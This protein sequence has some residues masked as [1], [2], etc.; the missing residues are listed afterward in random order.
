VTFL[1]NHWVTFFGGTVQVL[2]EGKGVER[3]INQ[4]TRSD[5]VIWNVKRQGTS[6][7]TFFIR[8]HH[9]H[10]LRHHVK[11]YE[12]RVSFLRGQGAP[13]LWKRIMKNGGFLAGLILFFAIITVLSNVVWG[14]QIKGASPKTEYQIRKELSNMGI[15]VGELQFFIDDVETIQHDLTN[16]IPN[17]TWVGVVLKGTTFHFQVVE[18]NTPKPAKPLP[19][20]HLVANQKAVITDMFVQSGK[21]VVKLHQYV[22]KGQLLVS[23]LVGSEEKPT[24]VAATGEVMGKIWYQSNVEMPLKSD[25]QVYTGK[26]KRKHAVEIGSLRIPFWGFGKIKYTKYDEEVESYPVKFLAWQLPI[27]YVEITAREKQMVVREYTNAQAVKAAKSL[28]RNDLKA[29]IPKDAKIVDE[30]TLH[31]KVENGKV[32]LALY[33]QVIENIAQA[34]P[35]IQG[36]KE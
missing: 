28:A 10:Q 8:L 31:E 27:K 7:V 1:K 19:P 12:C 14:I 5:L 3:F 16:R 36:D 29:K 23:G 13:F 35:I 6:A 21:P 17:I 18:K 2:V 25:F 33:F 11:K 15:H 30:Y 22:K 9:I 32:K 20:Q 24:P 26:E 4:L 34:K